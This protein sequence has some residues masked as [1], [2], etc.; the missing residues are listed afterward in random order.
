MKSPSSHGNP[1][2]TAQ[3][4]VKVTR[5][6]PFSHDWQK[7][8]NVLIGQGKGV[9]SVEDGIFASLGCALEMFSSFLLGCCSPH[10]ALHFRIQ[11][12]AFL[13]PSTN[14]QKHLSVLVSSKHLGRSRPNKYKIVAGIISF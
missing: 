1:N 3:G 12:E 6:I 13:S 2:H 10:L 11:S 5:Q 9:K 7:P 14:A 8:F 4:G